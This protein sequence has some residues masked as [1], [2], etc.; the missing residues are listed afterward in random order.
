MFRS[1]FKA[2]KIVNKNL[3]GTAHFCIDLDNQIL[4]FKY[5]DSN[6]NKKIKEI[7]DYIQD[8]NYGYTVKSI[9]FANAVK[10]LKNQIIKYYPKTAFQ[11]E[12]INFLEI[13]DEIR[14]VNFNL[15]EIF[16][17]FVVKI[18]R[19]HYKNLQIKLNANEEN[20]E[21]NVALHYSIE[22]DSNNSLSKQEKD[23]LFI[24]LNTTRFKHFEVIF[25][26]I[27]LSDDFYN[28]PYIILEEYLFNV[29]FL[30]NLS[31]LKL[32][33][34]FY[35][36]KEIIELDLSK[37]ESYFLENPINLNESSVLEINKVHDIS[38]F[39]YKKIELENDLLFRYILEIENLPDWKKS[40]LEINKNKLKVIN[41]MEIFEKFENFYL[42]NLFIGIKQM[43]I[44]SNILLIFIAKH[45]SIESEIIRINELNNLLEVF[46]ECNFSF[47]KYYFLSLIN[48]CF[49]TN[50]ILIQFM[51]KKDI[52]LN[53][54]IME[55]I[56]DS[57]YNCLN[58]DEVDNYSITGEEIELSFQFAGCKHHQTE[59]NQLYF[60]SLAEKHCN[61][62]IFLTF[63]CEKCKLKENSKLKIVLTKSKLNFRG[64]I[65][66]PFKLYKEVNRLF[67]T[68][69]DLNLNLKASLLNIKREE[70]I[71][72]IINL[73]F[74]SKCYNFSTENLL[75]LLKI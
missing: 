33:D 7:V 40:N 41:Y 32:V 37:Y 66:S 54:C 46:D 39:S 44:I 63:E 57:S 52:L 27:K 15:Q 48:K 23:F 71:L 72:I 55:H 61:E 8:I 62:D 25:D 29:K 4:D 10:T 45:S 50:I 31:L 9:Y 60:L 16:S 51:R 18:L 2:V 13:N 70:R 68:I 6:E 24:F 69:F 19:F 58:V 3:L 12:C 14:S 67:N 49:L 20:K 47:R 53:K 28:I 38:F 34:Y 5:I 75:N 22:T 56:N 35:I 43:I 1:G 17:S 26:N 42:K 74:Y 64:N 59:D 65:L 11:I 73:I 36:S 30:S 21:I